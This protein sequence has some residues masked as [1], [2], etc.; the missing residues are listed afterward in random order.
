[1]RALAGVLAAF[2]V[3]WTMS[4]QAA[5]DK[6]A[7][8][9]SGTWRLEYD[10][11]G[12]R[13]KDA[14]RLNLAK[15]GK[16]VGALHRGE[17]V[18]EIRNGK[19]EDNN[20]SFS[21]S[22]DYEGTP[23]VTKYNGKINGDEIDGTVVLE[24]NDQSWDF[25]WK[26]KRSVMMEDVVGTWQFLIEAADGNTFEPTLQ[27]SKDGEKYKSVYTSQQGAVLGVKGLRVEKNDLM[28]AISAELNGNTL[29]VDYRGRPYG[30]KIQ[31]TL[32]YDIA[33][34]TGNGEFTAKRKRQQEKKEPTSRSK[35]LQTGRRVP[36]FVLTDSDGK[37]VALADFNDAKFIVVVFMGTEC[38]IGNAYV[39]DLIELQKRYRDQNVQVIGVNANLSDSAETIAEHVAEFK[40]DFPVL[41]DNDQLAADLFDAQRTPEVF[42]L[43]R[44]RQIRYRGRIDDRVGYDFKRDESRR[45]DLEEAVQE[46]IAGKHVSVTETDLEGCLITRRASLRKKGEVTYGKHIAKILHDRCANC[47][48]SGTAAPFSLLTYEDARN[49]SEMINEVVK[50]RRMPP[51]NA[52]P[53]FGD[54]SNDLRMPKEEIDTLVAWIDDGAPLGNEQDLPERPQYA[55]GWTIGEPD[56]VFKMPEDYTVPA[57]G[58][59]EY[60]YFVTPTNFKEDVWVK[61]S[62]PRPGNRAVVHHIIVFVRPKD[63]K[64]FRNLPAVGGFA[65][66]E[67]P[68]VWPEGIGFRIPAGAELVWQVHYTP[69][70]KVETDRCEVGLIFCKEPPQRRVKGGGAFN[71]AFRIPPG[72]ENHR[73]VSS[74]K[75]SRDVELLAL[76]PHM[77]LRGKDFRY[78]A[79]YPDGRTEILLNVPDYDFNWQHRYR[80]AK[81]FLIPKGTTIECVAHFDNSADNPANPDPDKTVRWGDQT[82][83]EMMIGWYSHVD[84]P[85]R[86][87]D[88]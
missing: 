74:K 46:L 87:T 63:S 50:Q 62:E 70:G 72:A 1:M 25:Q 19:I 28:F 32:D 38:P 66:G 80:F 55:E 31:G 73:V 17:T 76:M 48:H 8:D 40:I 54:F 77:H 7:V 20:L 84:A 58:T 6:K 24:V 82:W 52:D 16:V 4:S 44:R 34:N 71:F 36:N 18:A 60:Q 41:V 79:R 33:G 83:E 42:V 81:P 88:K 47:H 59:V 57:A 35:N 67:E 10:W 26:P 49:R 37:E 56:V 11:D 23:W 65:P 30:D 2:F 53:R 75:F 21:V 86:L 5:E 78:T 15:N 69:T 45:A 27:V 29:K 85:A 61:A 12:T 14:F 68:M 51:W 39:P 9:P 43:D 22:I 3:T 13:I 64:S